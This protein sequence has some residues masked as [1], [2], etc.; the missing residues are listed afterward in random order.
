MRLAEVVQAGSAE[1]WV[2]V[3]KACHG[4]GGVDSHGAEAE[5]EE[6]GLIRK[7]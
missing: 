5:Q 3:E 1:R 7:T 2:I 4:Q 6:S